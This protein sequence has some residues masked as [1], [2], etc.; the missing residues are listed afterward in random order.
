MQHITIRKGD[1]R[2]Q[3]FRVR[4]Q[5]KNTGI[6][7]DFASLEEAKEFRDSFLKEH[8]FDGR[9]ERTGPRKTEEEI[10]ETTRMYRRTP[11]PCPCCQKLIPN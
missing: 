9:F 1:K 5:R 8:P 10:L 6:R 3:R 4:F 7:R 2:I 11:V